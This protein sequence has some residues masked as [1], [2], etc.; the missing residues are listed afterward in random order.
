VVGCVQGLA[1]PDPGLREKIE[2]NWLNVD[3]RIAVAGVATGP[4]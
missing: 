2:P 1:Y 3:D 4:V